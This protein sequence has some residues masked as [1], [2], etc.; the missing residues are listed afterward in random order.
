M[1]KIKYIGDPIL[2]N[3]SSPIELFDSNLKS[4][5]DEM[6]EIMYEEDGIGLAAP[7]IGLNIRLF[8]VDVSPV[9]KSGGKKVFINPEILH[10]WGENTLEE[11]C[12]SIPGV[13]EEV[14]RPNKIEIKYQ[15]E[16][17]QEITELLDE[18]PARVIQHEN[19]H[20]DGVLFV[21]RISPIRRKILQL[22]GEIPLLY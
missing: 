9:D 22:K 19:D 21:D 16:L 18:W 13:K 14:N 5:I 15:N 11:G 4:L 3:I 2:K 7:Q 10:S 6:F 1:Y 12:L 17:G 8:I 20:L